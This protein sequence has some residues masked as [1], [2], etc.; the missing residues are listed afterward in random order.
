LWT[1]IF[2]LTRGTRIEETKTDPEPKE[3]SLTGDSC[4]D[5]KEGSRHGD[6]LCSEALQRATGEHLSVLGTGET[7]QGEHLTSGTDDTGNLEMLTEKVG[8]LDLR[9]VKRNRSGV[10]RKWARS[11]R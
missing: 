10:P 3:S 9:Q 11:S 8:T 5:S 6:L 2:P 1:E 4:K 7:L